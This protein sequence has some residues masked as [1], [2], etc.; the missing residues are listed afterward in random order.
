[1]SGT[2]AQKTPYARKLNQF[3]E[4]KVLNALQTLGKSLP[5]YVIAVD[6]SIVTVRFEIET[7]FTLPDVTCPLFGPSYIRYP[8]QVNDKGIVISADYYI[9]SVTGLG[10]N[11]GDLSPRA[12]LSALIFL[13]V[14]NKNWTP[15]ENPDALVMTGP[16]GVILTSDDGDHKLIVDDTNVRTVGEFRGGPDGNQIIADD[17]NVRTTGTFR[18]GNGASGVFS[19]SGLQ[20]MVI[21]NGI[22][23]SIT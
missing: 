11:V 12:N 19:A 23:T 1:M 16:D 2:N 6:G 14:A 3:A 18:A 7:P 8:T 15:S 9:G 21:Q 13:P 4:K 17:S 10:G 5:C 22:V 20:T